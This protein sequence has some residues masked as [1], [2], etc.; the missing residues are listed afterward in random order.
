MFCATD[1]KANQPVVLEVSFVLSINEEAKAYK[2]HYVVAFQKL[3]IVS[4]ISF[5]LLKLGN[6]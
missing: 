6:Q 2:L 3:L 5:N 1:Y 4:F